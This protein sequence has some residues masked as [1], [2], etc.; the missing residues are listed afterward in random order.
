MNRLPFSALLLLLLCASTVAG[1]PAPLRSSYFPL[2]V[3][4]KWTYL[5]TDLRA[6]AK[7]DV[8]RRVVIEVER[9]ELY[10][11]MKAENMKVVATKYIGYLLKS[12]SGDKVTRDH[13]VVL[14]DGIFRVHAAD[15]PITPP[16]LFFKLG[17]QDTNKWEVNSTSGNTTLHGDFTI[18]ETTVSVPAVKDAKAIQVSYRSKK[19]GDER[20]EIDYWFV[21]KF[22]M[23]Q[24]RIRT[25]SH[26]VML[27]LEKY[28]PK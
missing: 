20:V 28:E 4:A 23:V 1:Q 8:E 25:K 21:E 5:A 17:K 14:P 27:K 12:T 6:K 22:G 26:E 3:G 10:V 24:Q 7:S 19:A 18:G 13:V 2:D 11:E 15:T 16:L 9:T